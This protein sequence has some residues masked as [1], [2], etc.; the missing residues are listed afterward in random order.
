MTNTLYINKNPVFGFVT[1]FSIRKNCGMKAT[2]IILVVCIYCVVKGNKI[3]LRVR[4]CSGAIARLTLNR[5]STISEFYKTIISLG[6]AKDDSF[7]I[8]GENKLSILSQLQN[9]TKLLDTSINHGDIVQVVEE[10]VNSGRQKKKTSFSKRIY[11]KS[12]SLADLVKHR[13]SLTKIRMQQANVD[14]LLRVSTSIERIL[15]RLNEYGGIALL[16]GNRERKTVP[17]NKAINYKMGTVA[18][19]SSIKAKEFPVKITNVVGAI[20]IAYGDNCTLDD[21]GRTLAQRSVALAA[22][23]GLEIVG[24]SVAPTSTRKDVC[25]F[26]NTSQNKV[27]S[28]TTSY[29]MSEQNMNH[30]DNNNNSDNITSDAMWNNIHVHVALQLREIISPDSVVVLATSSSS[31]GGGMDSSSS[32][33]ATSSSVKDKMDPFVILR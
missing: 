33:A 22:A 8:V 11:R 2:F 20:E 13:E 16:L 32:F 27:E 6:Y 18:S 10:L 4:Q 30:F 19:L 17:N 21:M 3:T 28:L 23:M 1:S 7:T 12:V 24:F 5:S 9:N 14:T 15:G 26:N 25:S 29:S 31:T